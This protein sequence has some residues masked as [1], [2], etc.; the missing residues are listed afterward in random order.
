M[1]SYKIVHDE[2][3]CIG[4]AACAAV[5]P[6]NWEMKGNKSI[7]K[8]TTISDKELDENMEAA[9]IC[10]VNCIHINEGKKKLI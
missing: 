7:P 9:K 6:N 5:S 2:D 3:V 4:C 8:K 1:T 10:P